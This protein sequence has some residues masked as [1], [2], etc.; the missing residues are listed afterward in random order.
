MGSENGP[1]QP[2]APY[3]LSICLYRF[4]GGAIVFG[5]WLSILIV[6]GVLEII[7]AHTVDCMG[8]SASEKVVSPLFPSAIMKH[9]NLVH[10]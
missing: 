4:S 9:P 2:L 7:Y 1:T 8:I 5:Q 3:G 10:L 6:H